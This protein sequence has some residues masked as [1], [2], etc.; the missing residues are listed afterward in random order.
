MYS[1]NLGVKGLRRWVCYRKSSKKRR[2]GGG[3]EGEERGV[4]LAARGHITYLGHDGSVR[5]VKP[6]LPPGDFLVA[7]VVVVSPS[8]VVCAGQVADGA[9]CGA[10]PAR[11][12]SD[13][14]HEEDLPPIQYNNYERVLQVQ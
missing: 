10:G 7:P 12:R 5:V 8:G 1:L 9:V 13:E 3:G 4:L 2:G 14:R 11:L 6:P